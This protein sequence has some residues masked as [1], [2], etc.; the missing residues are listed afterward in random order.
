MA[1]LYTP[2][3]TIISLFSINIVSA[4][5][6]AIK[7]K[8]QNRWQLA[9][10]V[11]KNSF[12]ATKHDF[13][14]MWRNLLAD[15]N[16]PVYG[17]TVLGLLA[18]DKP[19][20]SFYQSEI[21]TRINYSLP[22]ITINNI[23]EPW[24][25]GVD[26]YVGY[27]II[28]TYLGSVAFGSEQGQ[29]FAINAFKSIAYST[30]ITHITLKSLFGRQRPIRP[31]DSTTAVNSDNSRLEQPFTDDPYNFGNRRSEVLYSSPEASSLPSLHATA[32]AAVAQVA[33]REFNN[34]WGYGIMSILFLTDIEDH[35]HWVSDLVAG[36]LIGGMIGNAVVDSSLKQ[37]NPK[38]YK[39]KNGNRISLTPIITP[40][41][42][43]LR[44]SYSF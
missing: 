6:P 22:D 7:I 42:S 10:E 37:R 43:A 14:F 21:E 20:T 30:L 4:D 9:G 23:D 5:T 32:F 44:F 36:G 38:K 2:L 40:E 39:N 26:A 8:Q 24:L 19:I 31:L 15:K 27:S 13:R 33:V 18:L 3:F 41:A 16:T 12:V 11:I 1:K 17:A 28:G 35:N 34:Y 25:S 29:Y